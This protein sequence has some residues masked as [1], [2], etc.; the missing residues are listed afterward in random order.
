LP[1]L[2]DDLYAVS[3]V[4]K[5]EISKGIVQEHNGNNQTSV[6]LWIRQA[7]GIRLPTTISFLTQ[8]LP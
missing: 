3:G 7:H 6:R 1:E 4:P 2:F 8:F 5:P